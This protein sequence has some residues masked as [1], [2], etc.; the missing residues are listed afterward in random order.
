M[1]T[2]KPTAAEHNGFVIVPHAASKEVSQ[3]SPRAARSLKS[4]LEMVRPPCL[5]FGTSVLIVCGDKV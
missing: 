5:L 4:M 2:L 3:R 1:C